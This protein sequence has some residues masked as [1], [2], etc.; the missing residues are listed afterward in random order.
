M[1]ERRGGDV[2][3]T[4]K[5]VVAV[6]G[7]VADAQAFDDARDGEV[8][9]TPLTTN[10]DRRRYFY[11]AERRTYESFGIALVDAVQG[12]VPNHLRDG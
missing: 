1:I 6:L 2:F 8:V 11:K 7:A 12:L 10:R 5:R 9:T 3:R 4:D